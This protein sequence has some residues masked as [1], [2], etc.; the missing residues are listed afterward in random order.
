[1]SSRDLVDAYMA[2]QGQLPQAQQEEAPDLSASE[3]NSIKNYVG[4][5]DKY[6]ELMQ[7]SSE[8]LDEG[9]VKGFDDVVGRGNPQAIKLALKGLMAE[10]ESQFGSEGR[11]LTGKAPRQNAD[12]FR[13]Q[14]EVVQAMSD[15][16]YDK[17]AAYRND[18]FEKLGRSELNY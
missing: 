4:G 5:E 9:T 15:P 2:M 16:R 6:S 12:V 13:S 18:V 3:V 7:W 10:Y 8:N 17:D 14:A 11:M 1:M